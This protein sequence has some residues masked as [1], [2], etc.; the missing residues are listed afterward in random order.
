M[1][2]A[3]GAKLEDLN[4]GDFLDVVYS[5]ALNSPE[6]RNVIRSGILGYVFD[7]ME[8]EPEDAPTFDGFKSQA[9]NPSMLAEL[10]AFNT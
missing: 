1:L 9:L 4:L 5:Y 3:T 2:T 6:N 7:F 10:D 8:N